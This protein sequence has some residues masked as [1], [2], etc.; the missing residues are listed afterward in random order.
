MTDSL[1]SIADDRRDA[2]EAAFAPK[3]KAPTAK[4]KKTSKKK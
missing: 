2:R 4:A 1:R 3:P